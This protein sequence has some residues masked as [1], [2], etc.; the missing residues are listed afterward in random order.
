[1]KKHR[2]KARKPKRRAAAPVTQPELPTDGPG[3]YH[4]GQPDL[5][6][7]DH[8]LPA[9]EAG[10]V[11]QHLIERCERLGEEYIYDPA[12]AYVTS[13][14]EWAA[15]YSVYH[16][17]GR[18][19][20]YEVEPEGKIVRDPDIVHIDG[21]PLCDFS[22]RCDRARIVR[23]ITIPFRLKHRMRERVRASEGL[24]FDWVWLS[25]QPWK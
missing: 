8:I 25:V 22:Y 11:Q 13:N 3:Y 19:A 17:T 2:P 23:K 6:V 1:M 20:L 24:Y 5:Q 9:A 12:V 18:G 21:V 15:L 14:L 7:G 4:G 10:T 16:P